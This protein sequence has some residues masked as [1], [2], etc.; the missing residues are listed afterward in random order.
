MEAFY[1]DRPAW[2]HTGA[3][4]GEKNAD[5]PAPRRR[6]KPTAF[7]SEHTLE[8]ALLFDLV[9]ILS[10]LEF[11]IVPFFFWA[12]RE[13]SPKGRGS[14]PDSTLRLLAVFPRRP[15]VQAGNPLV[16]VKFNAEVQ[17]DAERLSRAGIPVVCGAPRGRSLEDCYLG[18]ACAWF[19][20]AHATDDDIGVDL[21][22]GIRVESS[23]GSPIIGP[24]H[25]DCLRGV[26]EGTSPVRW[27][28][29]LDA[30]FRVRPGG[31]RSSGLWGPH[32]YKPFYLAL[33]DGGA[34]PRA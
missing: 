16:H 4:P 22:S 9:R 1:E 27:S 15:K 3:L 33:L 26:V 20:I 10:P 7:A 25:E 28:E 23:D 21:D 11:R 14:F 19:S 31:K 24:L 6:G 29:A 17:E 13:G 5:P 34:V 2:C 18:C 12:S 8:Y 30:I 32:G